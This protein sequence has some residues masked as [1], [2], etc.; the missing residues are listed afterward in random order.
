MVKTNSKITEGPIFKSLFFFTVPIMLT[1]LLQVMYNMADNIVV[2]KFSG[3]PLALAAVGSTT[4]L[5][6]FFTNSL[7]NVATGGGVIIAQSYGARDYARTSRGIQTAMTFSLI[8]GI[9]LGAIAFALSS[10]MLELLGTKS[11]IFSRALLYFRIICIGIP[12]ITVYNFGAAILRSTGNSKTPLYILSASGIVNVLLNLFFVIV[13][14]MSVDG[15]AIATIISQYLSAIAVLFVLCRS[16][17]ESTRFDIKKLFI[18]GKL[19]SRMLSIGIPAALQSMM[20][21]ISNM[22]L[23]SATNTLSAVEVSAKTIAFNVDALLYTVL[24]SFSSGTMTFVGQNYGARS[25]DRIKKSILCAMVQIVAV[26]VL[27]GQS[28]ILFSK[29]IVGLY[30]DPLDP[31]APAV[32]EYAIELSIFILS[33]YFLCG[34]MESLTAAARALE[35]SV[36]PMIISIIGTCVFRA[37]W[38]IFIFPIPKFNSLVGLFICYPISWILVILSLIVFLLIVMKKTKK[39]MSSDEKKSETAQIS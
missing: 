7:L 3:D 39:L 4:A 17:E 6:A 24:N 32:S 23:T 18:D 12:A 29:E 15:V 28:M 25:Y 10:P 34:I 30:L 26:G 22:I 21:S 36:A 5:T 20:F 38:A 8:A 35:H 2:G 1:G 33:C 27:L 11:E 16:K 13:C 37:I 31:S 14:G 9:S 19:L